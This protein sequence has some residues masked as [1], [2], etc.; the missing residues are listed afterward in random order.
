MLL[1]SGASNIFFL[2][3]DETGLKLVTH[4][5]DGLVLPGITRDSILKLA[6]DVNPSIYVDERP[7]KIDELI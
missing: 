1:E 5:N 6:K 3:K 2:F 4:P 7:I